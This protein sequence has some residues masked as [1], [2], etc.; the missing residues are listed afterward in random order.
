M[1]VG[2]EEGDEETRESDQIGHQNPQTLN[3]DAAAALCRIDRG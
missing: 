3:P 2:S 1:R